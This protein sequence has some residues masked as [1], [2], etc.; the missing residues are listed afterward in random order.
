VG[1]PAAAPPPLGLGRA[2]A[3]RLANEWRSECH[4]SRPSVASRPTAS[5][6][7]SSA[8]RRFRS[9]TGLP[10]AVPITR[11][12]LPLVPC[13]KRSSPLRRHPPAPHSAS[14]NRRA[15]PNSRSAHSGQN[16][17]GRR[18]C[19]GRRATRHRR[20]RRS[21]A[22]GRTRHRRAVLWRSGGSPS[23]GNG[24]Y[25][26]GQVVGAAQ[27]RP[28]SFRWWIGASAKPSI[29]RR[30]FSTD[31][32]QQEGWRGEEGASPLLPRRRN[33]DYPETIRPRPRC[34]VPSS[35][36]SHCSG[37]LRSRPGAAQECSPSSSGCRGSCSSEPRFRRGRSRCCC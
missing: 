5:F 31:S 6:A 36:R 4:E 27:R 11:S 26:A 3:S 22:H 21:A 15:S 14:T 12:C 19:R 24:G 28:P 8:R 37:F 34:T 29:P 1:R 30:L 9:A 16:T 23:C 35:G 18:R 7:S 2:V 32:R 17:A 33:G 25:S 10:S 20:S 13:A